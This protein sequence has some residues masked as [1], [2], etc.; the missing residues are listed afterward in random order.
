[1]IDAAEAIRQ[2]VEGHD[3]SSPRGLLN[4][5]KADTAVKIPPGAPYSIATNVA[6]TLIWQDIWMCRLRGDKLPKVVMGQDFP[7]VSAEEWPDIRKRF[8]DGLDEAHEIAHRE[9]FT[10]GAKSDE[11]AIQ[12]LFKIA[13]HG[14]YHIGQVQLLKRLLKHG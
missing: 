2:V 3:F 14:S 13:N 5:I 10:H 11:L 7:Q 9:P 8:C 4:S 12:T 6:H 1:M